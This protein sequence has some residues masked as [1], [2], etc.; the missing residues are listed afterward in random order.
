VCPRNEKFAREVTTPALAPRA[1][2]ADVTREAYVAHPDGEAKIWAE[3]EVA[4]AVVIGLNPRQVAEAE[5]IVR[6]HLP[7]LR[8]AWRRHFGR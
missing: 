1:E 6:R 8:D 3:P 5:A 2:I 4:A 7:E